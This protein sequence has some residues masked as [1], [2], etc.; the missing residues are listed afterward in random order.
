[1]GI[2]V[3]VEVNESAYEFTKGISKFIVVVQREVADNGG[4][5]AGDDLP[6]IIASAVSDLGPAL[7]NV[8]G[9]GEEYAKNK[10]EFIQAMVVGFSEM[11]E[12]LAQKPEVKEPEA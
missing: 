12:I 3:E 11:A 4:W 6:G 10:K 5:A 2:K 1:M 9:L 8:M 7:T